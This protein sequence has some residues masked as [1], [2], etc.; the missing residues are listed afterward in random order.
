MSGAFSRQVDVFISRNLSPAAQSAALA[1]TA[2]R[3]VAD[4]IASGMASPR[5]R[6]SVD[7]VPDAPE[8]AVKPGGVIVY[9]FDFLGEVVAFALS[10]LQARSPFRSGDF[11]KSFYVGIDGKF[12]AASAFNPATM[13]HAAEIII[14][15]TQPYN[16][17]VDVQMAGGQRVKFSVPADMYSDAA[18][19]VRTRFG[20]LVRAYRNYNLSFPD[21]H[22]L[23][24]GKPVQSPG[25]VIA[26]R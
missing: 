9:R 5:Y 4:L 19:A 16:R 3:G 15:N 12:V 20:N 10:Y 1:E 14:G 25:L 2:R 18:A 17:L 21:K 7:G 26:V 24:N 23:Q 8:S 22:R 6:R 11:R 13:G